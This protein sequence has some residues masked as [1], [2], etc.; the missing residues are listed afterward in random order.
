VTDWYF[1]VE[2]TQLLDHL[3]LCYY[4]WTDKF[5]KERDNA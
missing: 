2:E 4:N 3:H 1:N 5:Q